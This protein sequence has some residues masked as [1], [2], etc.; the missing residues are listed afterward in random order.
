LANRKK[1]VK[2]KLSTWQ[3]SSFFELTRSHPKVSEET[4]GH[5]WGGIFCLYKVLLKRFM[6]ILHTPC[7][8]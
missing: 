3:F 2:P 8:R 6:V 4:F 7:I 1:H 5:S